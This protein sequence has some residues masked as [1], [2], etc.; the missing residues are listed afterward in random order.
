MKL[1]QGAHNY[2][3]IVLRRRQ[4]RRVEIAV[5]IDES[6]PSH[7]AAAAIDV[8]QHKLVPIR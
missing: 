3:D 8:P 1:Y 4:T 5:V 6:T 7:S 2:R